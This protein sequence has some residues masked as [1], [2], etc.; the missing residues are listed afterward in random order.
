M[1]LFD[2]FL[3]HG[4]FQPVLKNEK[5]VK[6]QRRSP[7]SCGN[8]F[9]LGAGGAAFF[10]FPLLLERKEYSSRGRYWRR[11]FLPSLAAR[12]IYRSRS[13]V[14]TTGI[15]QLAAPS[16]NRCMTEKSS[17]QAKNASAY[18]PDLFTKWTMAFSSQSR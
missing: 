2:T 11:Q 4:L 1:Q 16:S 15:K 18:Q 9:L 8:G 17:L 6:S 14:K 13:V 12:S 7:F 5:K 3:K 10:F